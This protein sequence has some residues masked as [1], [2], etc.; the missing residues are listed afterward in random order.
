MSVVNQI[1]NAGF[2]QTIEVASQLVFQL[3]Y[4]S[5]MARLLLKED[6][7][8]MA[9]STGVIGVGLIFV[10]GGMGTALIQKKKINDKYINAAL[11]TNLFIGLILCL[12]F[13]LLSGVIGSFYDD[14]RLSLIVKVLSFNIILLSVNNITLSILHKNFNF[15][16]SSLVSISATVLSNV[17][18]LIMALNGHGVWSLVYAT[19]SG[20]ALRT[21][22]FLYFAPIKLS[23]KLYFKEAKE[24]FVFGSGMMLLALSNFFSD[25]GL[26]LIFGK[27]FDSGTLGVYERAA[28]I[29]TLPSLF[30]GNVLD[31]VMFPVMSK[32]QDEEEQ[33]MSIFKFGLGLS[34]SLMIPLSIFLIVFTP[35]IV[36]LLMGDKWM[37]TIVP[38]QIMFVVLP[39]SNSGRMADSIIRA[40]GLVYKNVVRKYAFTAIILT[41][42]LVLG[43]FYGIIGAAIGV[44]VSYFI[45]YLMMIVL[46]NRV[47]NRAIKEVFVEPLVTGFKLGFSMLVLIFTYKAIF[48]FFWEIDVFHFIIFSILCLIL[49]FLI[50]RYKPR[51]LGIYISTTL[52]KYLKK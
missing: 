24:L 19:I 9:I 23:Y 3:V 14:G 1:K 2:W 33:L 29:K 27:I 34:N 38:L 17:L 51:F 5:I 36:S 20:S 47:F 40:K 18:G 44:S 12:V 42:S 46:V 50:G 6:Y 16:Y 32:L 31:K 30:I 4:F 11:Q 43:Y 52:S 10:R 48:G 28:H 35:E 13:F 45:N 37:E 49:L 7:G 15:K 25:K 39:F 21:M 26:N 22:G 41:L 8:L